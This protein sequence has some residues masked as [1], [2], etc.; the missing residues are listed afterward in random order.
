MP[1]LT[2]VLVVAVLLAGAAGNASAQRAEASR[3]Q[4]AI[5]VFQALVAVPEY[6]VPAAMMRKTFAV[7]IIPNVRRVGF[8]IGGQRGRGVLVARGD[9]GGWS[10]PLFITLTGASIG[11]QAGIQ[12][13][14]IVLFFRTRESVERVLQGSYTLGVDA[15]I[16]AGALG[17]SAAAS[18]D[19]DLTAEIYSYARARGIFAGVALQGATLAIDDAAADDYYNGTGLSAREVLAGTGLPMPPT[20]AQLQKVLEGYEKTLR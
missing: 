3:V 11:F 16:A 15:S 5:D 7:A 13:A 4:D 2:R 20:A 9:K 1:T 19:T 6:E 10:H 8:I 12:S 14:D 17:R 18:T